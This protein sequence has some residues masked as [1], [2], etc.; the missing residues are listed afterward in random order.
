[1]EALQESLQ[2]HKMD[3]QKIDSECQSLQKQIDEKKEKIQQLTTQLSQLTNEVAAKLTYHERIKSSHTDQ[4]TLR[5]ESI[6]KLTQSL[7]D[8]QKEHSLHS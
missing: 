4:L 3:F 6:S 5:Q 7:H 8:K 1:M 2:S